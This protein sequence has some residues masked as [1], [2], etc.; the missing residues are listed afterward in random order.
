[1]DKKQKLID[2]IMS[3]ISFLGIAWSLYTNDYPLTIVSSLLLLKTF[4]LAERIE[5]IKKEFENW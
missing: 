4:D 2:S 3:T 5:N 1:M